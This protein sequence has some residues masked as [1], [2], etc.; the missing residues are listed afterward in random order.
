MTKAKDEEWRKA[1]SVYDFNAKDINNEDVKLDKYK[2][3]EMSIVK[4]TSI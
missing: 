3:K 4:V 1:T 2:G